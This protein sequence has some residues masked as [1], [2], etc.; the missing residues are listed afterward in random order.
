MTYAEI[1][2]YD[3]ML[4]EIQE[5]IAKDRI[6][7]DKEERQGNG[8]NRDKRRAENSENNHELGL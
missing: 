1:E 8:V 4:T 6:E 5:Q 7:L 3:R 2:Y